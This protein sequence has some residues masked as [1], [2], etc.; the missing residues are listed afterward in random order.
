MVR[1]CG[2]TA[3]GVQHRAKGFNIEFR[4]ADGLC[5]P[6]LALAAILHAGFEGITERWECPDAMNEDPGRMSDPQKKKYASLLLPE[7]LAQALTHLEADAGLRSGF[8][9]E[10]FNLFVALRRDEL[11]KLGELSP[12]EACGRY[13]AIY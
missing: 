10:L 7:S 13:R 9:E 4:S 8:P 3:G 1:L 2:L 6:Y 12:A 11:A 5:N